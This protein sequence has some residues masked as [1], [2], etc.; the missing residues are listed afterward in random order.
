L[1]KSLVTVAIPALEELHVTDA[2]CCVLL[3]L[4]VPVAMKVGVSLTEI[5]AFPGVT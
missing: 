3:S 5:E 1:L 2:S 4:N